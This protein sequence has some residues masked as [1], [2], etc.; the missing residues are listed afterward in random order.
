[1]DPLIHSA[2][3]AFIGWALPRR[4]ASLGAVPLVVAGALLPDLDYFT[5]PFLDPRSAFAHRGFTH[6]LFGV[7]VLAPL[8][9]MAIQ[10]RETVYISRGSDS[11]WDALAPVAGPPDAYGSYAFL[12]VFS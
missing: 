9:G 4:Y 3:G 6:S 8:A 1:M 5:D 10:Q 2:A 12:P 11:Y 7:A